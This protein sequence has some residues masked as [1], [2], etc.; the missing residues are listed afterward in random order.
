MLSPLAWRQ[1]ADVGRLVFHRAR[2]HR[3]LVAM[4]KRDE[5]EERYTSGVVDEDPT[6]SAAVA[7]DEP[8]AAAMPSGSVA[9]R[10]CVL[11][12]KGAS[13]DAYVVIEQGAV[14]AVTT[15]KPQGVD[16]LIVTDGIVMPGLIDLHGHPEYNVFAPW[17]PPQLYK[18][19]GKWRDSDEYDAL[20]KQPYNKLTDQDHLTAALTRYAETRALVGGVTAIQGAAVSPQIVEESLVRNVDRRIFGQHIGRSVVD[21]GR[22]F[23]DDLK[24]FQDGV[25][26]GTITAV[27]VHLAEGVDQTSR[28]EFEQLKQKKLLGPATVIIHGT[29]LDQAQLTEAAA[30]GAKLV[31]SPQ[32]NLRL[33]G[34]TTQAKLARDLK[35]PLGLGADW[36][37]SGS[38][39]TLS[40]LKV[41]RHQLAAQGAKDDA[42]QLVG[43]VT[44]HAAEIAG[45]AGRPGQP[46]HLG[47]LQPGVPADVCVLERCH[48]D[49]WESVLRSDPSCVEM[50]MIA[51]NVAY[52][53][54]DWYQRLTQTA[55]PETVWAWGREMGLDVTYATRPGAAAPPRLAD[56]RATILK[57]YL[58]TGPI[59]A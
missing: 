5:F 50:T 14:T 10:G 25:T 20:I 18:N 8:A 36:V 53:R 12:S 54:S 11:S 56:L 58:Q 44:W 30:A 27:Y 32:S 13:E 34:Q 28:N 2:A 39:A 46:G 1:S 19:R 22:L 38:L 15:T 24:K 43:M 26:A 47:D 48:E 49:P 40:E 37:P 31:W 23:G 52:A 6:P 9:L 3:S 35:I 7:L 16:Q 45:L 21:L 4:A 55:P 33:Y 51:G 42:R 59:F 57:S 29:A 41:A 17:E